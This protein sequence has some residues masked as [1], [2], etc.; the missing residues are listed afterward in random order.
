ML[1]RR[2]LLA[3]TA[4]P[5]ALAVPRALRAQAFPSGDVRIV[6]G[7]PPGGTSDIFSRILADKL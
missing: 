1:R 5:A 2:A 7:A 3:A 4:A 6:S